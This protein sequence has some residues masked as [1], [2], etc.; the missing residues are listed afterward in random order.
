MSDVDMRILLSAVGGAGVIGT[1][2]SIAKALGGGGLGGALAAVGVAAAATAITIGVTAVKMAGDFQSSMTR[3]VTS[4]GEL[5][6]NLA[7]VSAGILKMSVDTATSTDQLS[8]AMYYVESSSYHGAAGLQVLTAAAQG[9][10]TENA[11]L[12][13][14]SKAL[15]G[16]MTNYS[17]PANQ[18]TSAMNGLVAVVQ[19]GTTSLQDLSSSMGAVLPTAASLHLSFAQV[20]GALDTMTS[21]LVPPQQAAQNLAHVLLALS[22]PSAVATKSMI[23][24][25]LSSQ[26]VKDALVSG[27]LP[28]AFQLI[29]D[30]VGSKFPAGSV[31]YITA[32]KNITGGLVGYKLAAQLSGPALKAT[33]QDTAKIAAAMKNGSGAVMGFTDV[34]GTFNF[35]MDQAKQATSALMI[36]IGTALLPVVTS[37]VSNIA[38]LIARFA[39]WLT[40]SGA[41]QAIAGGLSA[42]LG[43]LGT[44]ISTVVG[45]GMQFASFLQ[46]NELAMDV[47]KGLLIATALV[48]AAF[49]IPAMIGWAISLIPVAIE[50]LSV[51]LPILLII[52][53]VGL[54]VAAIILLVTHW[55]TVVAFLRN[56]WT[57]FASWFMG[58]IHAVG[59]FLMNVFTPVGAFLANVWRGIVA[60]LTAAWNVIKTVALVIFA[61][62]VFIIIL[63]FLPLINWF[64][65]HWAQVHAVLTAAWDI[66]KS[67]ASAVWNAIVSAIMAPVT[68]LISFF[69][70]HGEQIKAVL[71][72]A[73][74]VTQKLATDAWN[75]FSNIVITP[76]NN[77]VGLLKKAWDIVKT[78]FSA[79]MNTLSGF[80]TTAW[81]NV[82]AAVKTGVDVMIGIVNKM[83]SG[84]NSVTGAVGVPSIPLIPLLAQGGYNLSAGPYIVGDAGPEML[85]LPG[86]SSVVPMSR[87]GAGAGAT[88]RGGG[89]APIYNFYIAVSTMA[90]SQSEVNNLVD[91]IEQEIGNRVRQQTAGWSFGNVF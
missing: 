65:S 67:V 47:F 58:A 70:T 75:I 37:L 20:G 41:L 57:A 13:T 50:M 88:G 23:G 4:A 81:N 89:M 68:P 3:L 7:M 35:K 90:R 43:G 15:L 10:K 83:I 17:L 53:V 87:T 24:V 38:P 85:Y 40:K 66:T 55:S 79:G 22:A 49:V 6:Q 31:A 34:Q 1:V 48:I 72:A 84:V 42:A 61:L 19:N 25:G 11:D 71:S 39:D 18:A 30:H 60:S 46:H 52:I 2:D 36:T 91:L 44:A 32:M 26:Q 63:P 16:V 54:L 74:Q 80:A 27:G 12:T 59:T 5:P 29:E 82:S 9:A 21:K 73:W 28:G 45:W 8:S 77:L 76:V 62:I 78:D 56:I 14:V 86:G 33:E 51:T 69:Q 64:K